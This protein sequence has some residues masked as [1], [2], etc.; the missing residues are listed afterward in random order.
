MNIKY[1]SPSYK[2]AGSITTPYYIKKC[3]VYVSPKE[4]EEYV[5]LNPEIKDNFVALPEGVQGF[6][7]GKCLNWLLDNLW[8]DKTDAII[9]ID[10]DMSC[11]KAHVINGKDREIEEEEFYEIIEHYTDLAKQFGVGLWSFNLNSDPMTYDCFKP[12][13]FHSYLDGQVT[14][15]CE[16]NGIRYD[17]EL[18]IKEDVDFFLQNIAMYHK[19]LRVDKYY[20]VCKGFTNEGGCF[21]LRNA[22]EEQRQFKLMQ[23]KWGSSIIR[24]N[25]PTGKKASK[26][27]SFGGA[28]KI[29][30]PLKGV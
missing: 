29:N 9:C 10:D 23:E 20:P 5:R 15:W 11:L 26:I 18:S 30:L 27:R 4:Y 8:D 21:D 16:D 1:V 3:K 7:K 28:I 17:L 13:R 24:P 6:G 19:A 14:C 22:E 12:F 2:R 25:K